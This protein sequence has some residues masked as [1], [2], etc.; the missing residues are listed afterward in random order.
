MVW[1]EIDSRLRI[2]PAELPDGAEKELRDLFTHKNPKR[3][4]L[5]RAK[6]R[7]WWNEPVMIPTHGTDKAGRITL[8]RGGMSKV[9]QL[10]F[11]KGI[12]FRVRDRRIKV[13][14]DP[15][16][17]DSNVELR[18]YQERLVEAFEAKEN[19][20]GKS[21]TGSGKTTALLALYG[22]LKVPTIVV[23]HTLGLAEQW[24]ERAVAELGLSPKD[25]GMIGDG[26]FRLR[27]LTIG[28]VK[29]ISNAVEKD[30][31]FVNRWGCIMCDEVHLF[32]ARSL[33]A[34]VDKF[35]ARYRVG[36]SDDEKRK[37]QL[38]FLIYDLFGQV[39]A[40]VT[41]EELVDNGHVMDVEVLVVP[42]EFRADWYAVGDDDKSPD[43]GR[44]L[45]EMASD[46]D[47]NE[48]IQR[49]LSAELAEGRQ[50]IVFGK[51]RDHCR[52]IAS[53]VARQNVPSGFLIGGADYKAEFRRT[54]LGMKKGEIRVGIGT[55]QA[56]GIALDIPGVE[57]GIAAAPCLANRTT[58]RQGKGRVCRKPKGKTV[59]RLYV[60][61]D[62]E[63]FGLRHL[64]NAA[65]WAPTV[66]VWD[67]GRWVPVR[68][69]LK[70]ERMSL[71]E[72]DDGE[73]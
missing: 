50:V 45:A 21:G 46:D 36:A 17:P 27:H 62:R 42:T 30:P 54:K 69:F 43:Y 20:L 7:G 57:V 4:M 73:A 12:E 11:E 22:R 23:V 59:A 52:R 55:Y 37:D 14:W 56:C 25:V 40:H 8:P 19:C 34:V 2:D 72:A 63:V 32:A 33:F 47:R 18:G 35:P 41:D 16:V 48:V 3:A 31:D 44:L 65:R 58:F 6:V 51:E 5:Q 24:A 68:E 67:E 29:S 49:V 10:F 61:W 13:E 39:A 28:T 64:E 15:S 66:F 9:R 53:E 38:Q 70:K 1:I 26:Q 71:K 60:L